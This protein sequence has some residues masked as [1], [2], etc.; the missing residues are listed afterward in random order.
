MLNRNIY[1]VKRIWN[2]IHAFGKKEEILRCTLI[3]TQPKVWHQN[4]LN[5][6]CYQLQ[7]L[8]ILSNIHMIRLVKDTFNLENICMNRK[9]MFSNKTR[10][11]RK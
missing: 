9:N 6:F 2:E 10:C 7:Y 8:S 4:I 5:L 1:N 3:I 11:L